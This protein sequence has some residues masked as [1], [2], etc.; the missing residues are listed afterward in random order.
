MRY[1]PSEH[2]R[3]RLVI[4]GEQIERAMAHTKAAAAPSKPKAHSAVQGKS[5]P[6]KSGSS[7]QKGR[8]KGN[9]A[10][11]SGATSNQNPAKGGG[12][13]QTF[14]SNK[15]RK[16]LYAMSKG[17]DQIQV[18]DQYLAILKRK[19]KRAQRKAVYEKKRK[20][21]DQTGKSSKESSS[22]DSDDASV[23]VMDAEEVKKARWEDLKRHFKATMDRH[24][25]RQVTFNP[26]DQLEEEAA[27]KKT[28]QGMDS[29][30]SEANT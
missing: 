27:F 8:K 3:T 17:K 20:A 12:S 6:A 1:I 22:E 28:C 13:G 9:P 30:E 19:R 7:F 21:K 26:D 24:H 11:G 15:F 23:H 10:S 29:E 14:S 2:D 4:E 18:I 5:T 16:E 25:K